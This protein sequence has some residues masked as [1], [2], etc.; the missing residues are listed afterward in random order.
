MNHTSHNTQNCNLIVVSKVDGQDSVALH[1]LTSFPLVSLHGKLTVN[2]DNHNF[3]FVIGKTSIN[4]KH[5][6]VMD[7]STDHWIARCFGYE[8]C[9]WSIYISRSLIV[10]TRF[11]VILSRRGESGTDS[12]IVE[13]NRCGSFI[14]YFTRKLH[15]CSFRKS[16][17]VIKNLITM[18]YKAAKE[19]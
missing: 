13:G 15:V 6:S 2:A 1:W 17:I 16:I 4:C 5:V 12:N 11:I 8:C 7:S 9:L 18:Y 3:V 14:G 10:Q 19:G